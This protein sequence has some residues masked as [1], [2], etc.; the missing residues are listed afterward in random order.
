MADYASIPL[1]ALIG[2]QNLLDDFQLEEAAS[3]MDAKGVTAFQSLI[4]LGYLDEDTIVQTMCDHLGCE[5]MDLNDAMITPELIAQL[6]AELA[7]QHQC[8]PVS[9]FDPTLQLAFVDPLNP[10]ALDE[11]GF[12]TG[13]DVQVVVAN[14]EQEFRKIY[15]FIGIP[16]YPHYFDNLKQVS[17]NGLSYDDRA[18][19]NNMHKLFDGPIRKVYNPYIEKIPTRIKEKYEHIRF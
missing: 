6:P 13:F 7:K 9:F 3:E 4:D 17:I 10:A 1:L 8:V 18:V 14:P 15:E 5:S 16:Y 12:T 19:G 2:D 11:I